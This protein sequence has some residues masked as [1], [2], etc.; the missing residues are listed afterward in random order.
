MPVGKGT[1]ASGVMRYSLLVVISLLSVLMKCHF[2]D[3]AKMQLAILF[4]ECFFFLYSQAANIIW[5]YPGNPLVSMYGLSFGWVITALCLLCSA[6]LLRCFA[7][8]TSTFRIFK[9]WFMLSV[10][11]SS[12]G[13][14]REVWRAQKKRKSCL[15]RNSSFLSALQTSQVHP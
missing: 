8:C 14:T 4:S 1:I 13:C 5:I 15:R 6:N 11:I 3:K 7:K 9:N 2:L 10:R 12:Y